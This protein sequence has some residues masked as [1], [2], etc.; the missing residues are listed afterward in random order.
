MALVTLQQHR[1]QQGISGERNPTG[2]YGLSWCI[3]LYTN[4][5]SAY[6]EKPMDLAPND[7]LPIDGQQ[8]TT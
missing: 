6:P 3:S 1:I 4:G 5:Y 7:G 8:L 2:W